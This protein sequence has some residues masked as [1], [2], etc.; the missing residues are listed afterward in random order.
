[1]FKSLAVCLSLGVL[2]L[3]W[4]LVA[5][6]APDR[7]AQRVAAKKTYEAGNYKDAYTTFRKLA[8]DAQSDRQAVVDD[9][10]HGTSCLQSLGRVAEI[11]EFREAVVKV[12]DKNWRLLEAA[13]Q[14]YINIEHFGFIIAGKFERG[15]HRGGQG[16]YVDAM[17]RDQVRALQL[18]HQA[19][20]LARD[21]ADRPAVARL[22]LGFA[23]AFQ[24]GVWENAAWRLQVL[25]DLTQLPDYD[26][27]Y[28]AWGGE[29]A[30]GAPVD[31][32]G[33]PVFHRVPK[34]FEDAKSDGER[35]RWLLQQAVEINP[36]V[37]D[38]AD[39]MFANFL[40]DQFGV[41]T[42]IQYRLG[43][44][45][46]GLAG[47]DADDLK[48]DESGTYALHTLTED[49]TIA[50]LATGIKR[51]KLPDE[52]NCIKAYRRIADRSRS[53]RA[54]E[55]LESLAQEF[56]NRRQYPTAAE[57]WR[58]AIKVYG[59]G[60]SDKHRQQ[61]LDQI[62]GN[63][64]RFENG[65]TQ[66]AGKG[67]VVDFRFRNGKKVSFE[68][69]E[70]LV[71][72]LLADVKAYLKASPPQLDWQRMNIHDIGYRL[73]EQ[74]Q[75][76]YVGSRVAQWDLDLK[77]R[78]NHVDDRVTVTTPLQKPGAYLV[79]ARMADGN[80]SRI[81][82]WVADT[83]IVKKQLDGKAFYFVADAVSGLPVAKANVELF[84]WKQEPVGK[85][86]ER[87][88]TVVKN[89]AEFT[90]NDGQL[91]LDDKR[92]PHDHQWLLTATTPAGRLAYLGFTHVWYGSYHDQEYHATK[93]FSITDRP[94]YRPAQTVQFKQWVRMAKY[95]QEDTS[96]FA[97][98]SFVVRIHNPKGE[99]VLDKAVTAD[100]YGG[101]TG[102]LKLARDAT[103]GVYGI[104]IHHAENPDA[105]NLG[106]GNFR[107]EEY[108][109]PE[110]EVTV[111]ASR[112]PVKL[113]DKITATIHA[114]YFFGAPVTK[115]RVKFKVQRTNYNGNWYPAASWDWFYGRG[116]WWFASDYA[117]YPGFL[118]WGC[119]RPIPWWW[120]SPQPPPELVIDT[121][122]PIG[123]DGSIK[124]EIDSALAKELHGD[125]DHS[126]SITAEV[127]DES[128]RTIVGTGNVLVA[129]QPFRVFTWVDRGHYRTGDDIQ[130]SVQ[131][132][133]LDQKPV[134]G[135]GELTLFGITYN[136]KNEPVEKPV[137]TWKLDTDEQGH[138][139]R[140][141]KAAK[142]GQ[143]RLSY[144]LTDAAKHTIE[145]GYVFVVRGDTFD[146]REFRFND[147]EL[148]TDKREY[149]PGEKVKLLVNTN[150]TGGAVVLFLRPAN[151]VYLPPQIVRLDGKSTVREIDVVKKDMPNFFIEA[152]TVSNSRI[153]SELREVIVPPEK[154]VLNVA[155]TPSDSEYK[156]GSPAKVNVKLTDF[157][158]KPFVGQTVLTMYDKSLEYISGG[159]NVSN[160]REFF[161]KWRRQHH[162]H[163]ESSLDR[164]FWNVVKSGEVAMSDLGVFGAGI[165]DDVAGLWGEGQGMGLGMR[166]NRMTLTATR[167]MA[168]G[169][170]GGGLGGMGPMSESAAPAG[171]SAGAPPGFVDLDFYAKDAGADKSGLGT[172]SPSALLVQPTV[173]TKFADTVFWAASIVTDA[174]GEAEISLTMPENLTGWKVK[175]WG[176][177]HGTKVGEGEVEVVTKKNLLVRLQ[178]PRFFVEKDEV[179]VSANVHNYLKVDKRVEVV[180]EL[181]GN[182][183]SALAPLGRGAGGEG[184]SARTSA[185]SS[186]DDLSSQ[187]SPQGGE[188]VR[189]ITIPA[190]GE[191]RVDWR[192]KVLRE[193]QAIVRMKALSDEESDAMEQTFPV[194]VHGMLKTE[195]WA[196]VIRPDKT[197]ASV[198]INVPAERRIN[199]SRLEVRYSPTLAGAMVDA[200]P[201]LVGYPYGCTEQTLNRFVPTVV[202]QK[203]LQR[204]NLD[205]K[206]IRDKRTNLNAQEI[207]DDRDRAKG[208]KRWEQ[209]P[210]F[211]VEE[212][213]AMVKEGVERLTNMQCSDGGWGW[214]SGWG[215][216]SYPHTTAVVVH[217]LQVA[218]QNDV[219]LVPGVL[220]RGVEWLKR[221][222][223]QQVELL[224]AG[225]RRR[226]AKTDADRDRIRSWKDAGDNL[227]AFVYMVLVDADVASV[228][229]LDYLYR[230]RTHLAVYGKA[231]YGLALH[232]QQ[233]DEKLAMVLKNIE[234]FLEQDD[235]N[236]TAWLRLPEGNPWWH[237][238]G[239]EI[240]AHAYYLKLLARVA[241]KDERASRL[242]KYL[243]N[244]RKHATYWNSTRDTSLCI[245]AL[246][247][248]MIAS[249]EDQPDLTLEVWLD[250][251]RQKEVAINRDNLFTFDN[252]F[253]QFGDA[254]ETGK[255]TLELRKQGNGPV[256]F[257]AYLTNFTL[258]DFITKAGLEVKVNRK[259][260]RLT[261]VD[262][263]V[264]VAGSKGQALKQKVEKFERTELPNLGTLKS[265]DLVEI[266]L[267]IDSKNDYEY[268]M[269]E[270]LKAA[271]FEPVDVRSG[272]T[273]NELGAYVE[274]RDERV[275]FFT[276]A[277]ARGKHS[278]SYR[279][280]A[281]IPGKFSALP[282]RASAMYAPE[283]RA[284]SEEMKVAVED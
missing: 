240:E 7:Q 169:M 55:A 102:E 212:V 188:G 228:E 269:F 79:T 233:Q 123:A 186:S 259:F 254:V 267:E 136:S 87:Y 278:V 153:H 117:W 171:P 61:R 74:N 162:P 222:Q 70:I 143:Y 196:G 94:V 11:D 204:M 122:A 35:W 128:R 181:D 72:K 279:L 265:G 2:T 1:M 256:Y 103:L 97:G 108:K 48:K 192:V 65:Q 187:P 58:R 179:V 189:H 16:R 95:D 248:Y 71:S 22:H 32:A 118:R 93:V 152:L 17:H 20:A 268:L 151:G 101:V 80:L 145:G 39:L 272:Y 140:Q 23:H 57:I 124:V 221:Y 280:R 276:R 232:K 218:T 104:S 182:T 193:G 91:L 270:D 165:V 63:W 129:R 239:S 242:V 126:Y 33:N 37:R 24:Y 4:F 25:T 159:S 170:G 89:F 223:S 185:D 206:A 141:I 237:W 198:T 9:L 202:T 184:R 215:E 130:A 92:Q 67:A 207:G 12:H 86:Q 106:G 13:A 59:P 28:R 21:D 190:G 64:G 158:G 217:G 38:E 177:G 82:V 201:Y 47:G 29:Q 156:S 160:I 111:E 275:C 176:L 112:E 246:A 73:V 211:D 250:G 45:Q 36:R 146:G 15:Q 26:E 107:V 43:L 220:E 69:H 166:F 161:W 168:G 213:Q 236:Q 226:E 173:R 115:A 167:G 62:V 66:P 260:Y 172:G 180:L 30:P 219:A 132:H 234:Q 5:A 227:D 53:M 6:E 98:K 121:E 224:K 209:N 120:Q 243:L 174:K 150:R 46:P 14:S 199:E 273:G 249:G 247:E 44:W 113:G 88:R 157:S 114:K 274:F 135:T 90:D 31:D 19:A 139:R 142:P 149:A 77:P 164:R 75:R 10:N 50:K 42:M 282:T 263:Q 54:S 281:E 194:F 208:W 109:K 84:G 52:F 110:F 155:V 241:P 40:R 76:E 144:K 197:S 238:Y 200:L 96:D 262:K 257:N 277:L 216:H 253:L 261:K 252:Q 191:Q 264:D 147:I 119:L 195:S 138:A 105:T 178:S 85:N 154:R 283:L 255:H 18:Y 116:Y 214:F 235:E 100:E 271:G 229:M 245:E 51:I 78:P 49:E 266:E 34:S 203:I 210:V 244:N 41:Q 56:E 99:R 251:K 8:L 81:I 68:A 163:A 27:G 231:L 284:N 60:G 83:V 134:P 131:A 205:L 148:V 225:D 125:Q 175:A 230:D 133:T 127:T 183:L 258:E 137:E 3:S